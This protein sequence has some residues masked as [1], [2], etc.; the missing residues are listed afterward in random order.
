MCATCKNLHVIQQN[1][2]ILKV[3][4]CTVYELKQVFIYYEILFHYLAVKFLYFYLSIY[5]VEYNINTQIFSI[6][7]I[8]VYR[9]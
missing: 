2:K 4:S 8:Y 6:I 9:V 1:I 5:Y 7:E 3:P